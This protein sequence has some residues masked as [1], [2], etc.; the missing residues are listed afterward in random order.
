VS[1]ESFSSN[2]C[3]MSHVYT[4]LTLQW[5][6]V[7]TVCEGGVDAAGSGQGSMAGF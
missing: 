5:V 6:G 2:G 4:G 7:G 3:C 1:R